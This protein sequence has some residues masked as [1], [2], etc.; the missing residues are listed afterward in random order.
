MRE[1]LWEVLRTESRI[2]E[3]WGE[4]EE[5]EMKMLLE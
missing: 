5:K 3:E 1:C 4:L 2:E